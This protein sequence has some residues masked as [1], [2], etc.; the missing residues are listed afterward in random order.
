RLGEPDGARLGDARR[1]PR[2]VDRKRRG[3]SRR[4]VALQ[5]DERF[6]RA[7][8]G[9]A[10]RGAVAEALDDS[11]NPL[12]VEVLARDDDNAAALEVDRG[13]QDAAVPESHD[14]LAAAADD[15]LIPIGA[16]HAPAERGSKRR[17]DGIT[18]GRDQA[19]LQALR[20][21]CSPVGRRHPLAF[22]RRPSTYVMRSTNCVSAPAL[23]CAPFSMLE[24]NGHALTTVAAPV[25]CSCLKRRSLMRLPGSSSL[26]AKSSPPPAPQQYGLSRLRS[27]SFTSPPN[28]DNSSR[29]SST[30]PA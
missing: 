30:F 12:A 24:Q 25:A 8:R 16:I 22:F 17:D 13:G 19:R 7:A 1:S 29:G 3:L 2:P 9:P 10:T 28:F 15:A 11:R 5:L 26:S 14:R 23:A 20:A 27:G 18:D 4:H 21:R 6:H